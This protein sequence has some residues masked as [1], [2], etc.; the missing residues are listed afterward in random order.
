[1]EAPVG[2]AAYLITEFAVMRESAAIIEWI[3][4]LVAVKCSKLSTGSAKITGYHR[5]VGT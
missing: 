4:S 2:V 5:W 3:A 1:M